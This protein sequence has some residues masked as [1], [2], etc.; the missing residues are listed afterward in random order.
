MI[1]MALETV[2]FQQ[3]P[4]SCDCHLKDSLSLKQNDESTWAKSRGFGFGATCSSSDHNGFS[5]A[6]SAPPCRR[7]RWRRDGV[8]N[9]EEVEHQRM[10]H[11]IVERKRRKQMNDY[12]G[13][14]KSLMPASYVQRGD[15]ASIIGGAIDY[16]KGVGTASSIFR[17]TENKG[18]KLRE[19]HRFFHFLG[20]L[21]LSQIEDGCTVSSV[22]EIAEAIYEMVG[23]FQEESPG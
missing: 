21:L 6:K 14:L 11:I 8:K 7:K 15:Q 19:L 13:V 2:V 5:A 9:R 23:R 20:I 18:K 12:L 4:F 22:N 17:I 16:V 1:S 3:D 10:N